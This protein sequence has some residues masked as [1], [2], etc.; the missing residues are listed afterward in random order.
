MELETAV[1]SKLPLIILV[2]NNNGIYHGLDAQEFEDSRTSKT[3]PSTALLPDTR[4]DMISVACGGKGWLAR[5]QAELGAAL[6]EALQ[7]KDTTSVINVLIRPGG[8]TKLVSSKV[9][10]VRKFV[11]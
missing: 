6:K 9:I 3:L 4:Y 8:R 11:Y 2:I 1:R 10:F 5:N 7:V